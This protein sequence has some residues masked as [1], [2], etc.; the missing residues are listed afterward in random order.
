MDSF[1][2]S[3]ARLIDSAIKFSKVDSKVLRDYFSKAIVRLSNIPRDPN[4]TMFPGELTSKSQVQKTASSLEQKKRLEAWRVA[5]VNSLMEERARGEGISN[6]DKN[7]P[8]YRKFAVA[9]QERMRVIHEERIKKASEIFARNP[10]E[11]MS[12]K[13]YNDFIYE[14]NVALHGSDEAARKHLVL[15]ALNRRATTPHILQRNVIDLQRFLSGVHIDESDFGSYEDME[16]FFSYYNNVANNR[17]HQ[18]NA[19]GAG[20]EGPK[21][22]QIQVLQGE[23]GDINQMGMW[24]IREMDNSRERTNDLFMIQRMMDLARGYAPPASLGYDK[25]T[26]S[27]EE[28][29]RARDERSKREIEAMELNRYLSSLHPDTEFTFGDIKITIR[30]WR[31]KNHKMAGNYLERERMRTQLPAKVGERG[32]AKS[33]ALVAGCHQDF[34]DPLFFGS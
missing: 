5:H 20:P 21:E 27:R 17:M 25:N 28:Y 2:D 11:H 13:Q 19:Y 29:F 22:S 15:F 30:E 16:I 3:T 18:G 10:I 8:A 24:D 34:C 23:P 14:M 31:K 1:L 26:E 6:E 32:S 4:Q 33:S 7:S 12:P 9:E